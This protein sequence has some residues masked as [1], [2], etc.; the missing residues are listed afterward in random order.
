MLTAECPDQ[1]FTEEHVAMRAA[2][3]KFV[4]A[5]IAPH[6]EAWE[7]AGRVPRETYRKAG[8]TGLIGVSYPE[9]LGGL[10]GDPFMAVAVHEE[11]CRC[12]SGGVVAALGSHA[13]SMP[14]VVA[15]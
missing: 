6:I 3:R 14:L 15:H 13:I 11:V 12:G 1:Y 8:E 5:E 2:M 7:E 4:A 10:G 9:E